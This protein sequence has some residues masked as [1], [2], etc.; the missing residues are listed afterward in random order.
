[1]KLRVNDLIAQIT[2]QLKRSQTADGSWAYPFETG[3]STDAYMIILLRTLG[4]NDEEL[5]RGLAER[6]LSRQAT[7]GAWK[8]FQDE[9]GGNVT[10]TAEAYYALL[11]SG[12][13]AKGDARLQAAKTFI[14][15]KGGIENTH[16]LAKIMFAL[17][18]QYRWPP[19]FPI[20]IEAVL[21]P[22]SFPVNLYDLSV[23]GRANLIPILVVAAKK[24]KK[25]TKK[26]P[27]LSD[28][29]ISRSDDSFHWP[30]NQETQKLRAAMENEIK[31]LPRLPYSIHSAAMQRAKQYMLDHIEPDGTLYSYFSSTFLMIFALLSLGYAKSDPVI[32]EA[33][34]GLKSM[35][36]TI[37]GHPHIQYTTA[38]VWNTALISYALQEAEV[39]PSDP[40]IQTA[41]R[42]LL[43]RQQYK[44]GDW[45]FHNP[46]AFPGGWGF[47]NINTMNPDVDDTTASLRSLASLVNSSSTVYQSWKKGVGWTMSMQNTDGGWPAFEKNSNKKLF[48]FLPI[49]GARFLLTDPSSADLTG[50][51]LEFFGSYTN[52]Q[53]KHS[54][55][56][57]GTD[58][59]IEN[60]ETD[61]SWYG[62]WGICYIYGTWAAVTGLTATGTGTQAPVIQRAVHWLCRI[63]NED[64]GWGESCTSDIK[65]T[66]IPLGSS[67][68]IHTSWAL[69]A[70]I[71]AA[72]KPTKEIRAGLS[73]LLRSFHKND[74]TI[75]YPAGQGMAGS[76]YIHYHSYR[77]IFPL[78]ALAHYKR[79]FG[80]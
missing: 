40:V 65:R 76:F 28:L 75:D 77:Y 5:I 46:K 10:A 48:N 37:G 36:C 9:K 44:Y 33:V 1:M 7:N 24:Y 30:N 60:Q 49:E 3:I 4:I 34:A 16:M 61:G 38:S 13:V 70:L 32:L 51:T 69:D 53:K 64:G 78:L 23:F 41:S 58:W 18:G 45:V 15:A 20:P 57:K 14:R 71:A 29:F 22:L 55:L 2:E 52:M 43:R 11:Y 21:L 47:S 59:L 31:H 80:G 27:D 72:D 12:Y 35:K 56:K 8:L 25:K 79:K 6:I 39:S 68:L 50:R 26:S 17:T 42:Y 54:L 74:W 66:Y 67:T 62:R 73:Y 63:Q 19:C